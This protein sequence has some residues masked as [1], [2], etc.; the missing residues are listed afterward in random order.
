MR[1]QLSADFAPVIED[2]A[3]EGELRLC[4]ARIRDQHWRLYG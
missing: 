2:R 4:L 1:E 3:L